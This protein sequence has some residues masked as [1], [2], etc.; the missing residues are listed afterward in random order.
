MPLNSKSLSGYPPNYRDAKA[1]SQEI[2]QEGRIPSHS[3]EVGLDL[4]QFREEEKEAYNF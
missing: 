3:L 1:I 2:P 4:D